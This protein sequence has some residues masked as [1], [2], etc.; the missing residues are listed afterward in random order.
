MASAA[1]SAISRY[2]NNINISKRA[3]RLRNKHRHGA[4]RWRIKAA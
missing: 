1:I 2:R 3:H 4:Y